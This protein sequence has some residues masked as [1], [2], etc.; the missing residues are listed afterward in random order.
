V[1]RVGIVGAPR[2]SASVGK[3]NYGETSPEERDMLRYA[4][5]GNE[6]TVAPSYKHLANSRV[7]VTPVPKRPL[8][9][10]GAQEGE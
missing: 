8:T 3:A 1:R 5:A 7:F 10:C 9:P 2:A 4:R 6:S